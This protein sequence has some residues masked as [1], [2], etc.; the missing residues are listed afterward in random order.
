MASIG[1]IFAEARRAK[2]VTVQEVEK[3]IKIRAKYLAAMEE[4]NFNVIPGQAYIIGFI[5]TYANYLGLDGKDLI[6]RYYQEYQPP[7]D[8]SN[9]DLLNASKEK[10]K[11]TNFR[12]SLAIVI[13]LILLIGTIL[14]INSKNKSSGQES[15]RKVKQ[16]EQRR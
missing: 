2:G 15:L 13:F 3:S 14:I 7:G 6:A 9:Y 8:K 1:E 12:R 10:P 4:N 16:L 11:S 5:K